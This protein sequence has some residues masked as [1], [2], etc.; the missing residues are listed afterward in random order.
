MIRHRIGIADDDKSQLRA[1]R[2]LLVLNDF[3][4]HL[5]ESAHDFLAGYEVAKLDCA[6]LDLDLPDLNGLELQDRLRRQAA[7]L[8]V[9]FLSGVGDIPSSVQA[10]RNGAINFL[11]KPVEESALLEALQLAMAEGAKAR[12]EATE[13]SAL[14][15]RIQRLTQRE[16]EVLRH[17]IAGQL[18]KQ[19][20]A[21]LGISEQ[22]VKVHRMR[23]TEKTGLIS[24]AEL[25]RTAERLS[26]APAAMQGTAFAA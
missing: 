26:I 9:V 13:K 24:V 16:F 25:V 4:V 3:D 18:N 8:P 6:L 11:T 20:A 2:R 12:V 1:L 19:I 14:R 5:F 22:T 23:I 15:K 21:D 10:I 7:V 17:V